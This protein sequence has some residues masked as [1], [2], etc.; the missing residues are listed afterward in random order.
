MKEIIGRGRKR[1]RGVW[2]VET[3][4]VEY[5]ARWLNSTRGRLLIVLINGT[6]S[7]EREGERERDGEGRGGGEG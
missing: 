6:C 2:V 1:E 7:I 5:E 3:H 4:N